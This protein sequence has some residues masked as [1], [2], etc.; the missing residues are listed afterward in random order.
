L[1]IPYRELPKI[2][3]RRIGEIKAERGQ[4]RGDLV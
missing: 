1:G 2:A 3:K 4:K